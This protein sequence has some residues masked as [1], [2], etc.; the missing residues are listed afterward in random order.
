MT[1]S[2]LSDLMLTIADRG[3]GLLGRN[4]RKA[5][6]GVGGLVELCNALLSGHGEATGMAIAREV[7]DRFTGLDAAARLAFFQQLA[8]R[9]GTDAAPL[10]EA[11]DIW[12]KDPTDEHAADLHFVSEPRRQELFRRLNRAPHGTAALV[13]MRSGLLDLLPENP[14]LAGVDRDFLHLLSSWFN[15]GFLVLRP[16]DWSTPAIV[17]EK[18]IRYEAVHEIRDWNDLRRR[19]GL[20]DRRCYAFF[21]PALADEPLIFVEVALTG[22]MPAAIDPI[23]ATDREPIR[24][25]EA[26]TATFYSIS[27]CQKGLRGVSFGNFLIKQVVDEL[28][29]ELPEVKTFVT[30]SPVPGFKRWLG[31]FLEDESSGFLNAADRAI[32]DSLGANGWA[33]ERTAAEA[34]KT[35]LLPL[36]AHYF[37]RARNTHG[38]PV[39]PVA[40]FH[41]GNGARLER[42]NWLGDTS[43]KGLSRAAGLMVN[44]R[45]VLK[46]IEK[47]HEAYANHGEIAASS[48]VSKLLKQLHQ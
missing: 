25:H 29:R 36:T 2:I 18:I 14:G 40:R 24:P 41:L 37:L 30:L 22:K 32:L 19:I 17:L 16:I 5:D 20:P 35:V 7:M 48:G 43:E 27:T 10:E 44:Y 39:D 38:E 45:Y 31:R 33:Q 21:H 47:N 46:D 34:L 3:R 42:I 26:G 6:P 1:G 12:R 4:E 15:R 13:A 8:D 11:I 28:V 23:L 9:F